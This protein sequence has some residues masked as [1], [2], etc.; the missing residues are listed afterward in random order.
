MLLKP[1]GDIKLGERDAACGRPGWLTGKTAGQESCHTAD[2]SCSSDVS[3]LGY[4]TV[5][6]MQKYENDSGIIGVE[7]MNRWPAD[8]EAVNFLSM[9]TSA[10]SVDELKKVS[11]MEHRSPVR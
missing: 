7:D 11:T 4:I 5:E 6:L 8:S 2:R 1:D 10:G 9:T 3:A